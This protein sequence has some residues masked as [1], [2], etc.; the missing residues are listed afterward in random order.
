M[1][2]VVVE[3]PIEPG[4]CLPQRRLASRACARTPP[5]VTHGR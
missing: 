3:F 4:L 1:Y 2:V 5:T